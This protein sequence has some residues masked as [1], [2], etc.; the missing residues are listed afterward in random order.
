M[1]LV[2]N[3]VALLK[4]IYSQHGTVSRMQKFER[5]IQNFDQKMNF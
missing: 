3:K 2:H 4:M 1:S 5:Y